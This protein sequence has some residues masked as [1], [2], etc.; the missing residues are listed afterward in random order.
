LVFLCLPQISN[1]TSENLK[2]APSDALLIGQTMSVL[3]QFVSDLFLVDKEIEVVA[4]QRARAEAKISLHLSLWQHDLEMKEQS[5]GS[6]AKTFEW[7]GPLVGVTKYTAIAPRTPHFCKHLSQGNGNVLNGSLYIEIWKPQPNIMTL[8]LQKVYPIISGGGVPNK[9][10]PN[11]LLISTIHDEKWTIDLEFGADK[12][13]D[14]VS[15][16]HDSETH[17][18]LTSYLED[19]AT[20]RIADRVRHMAQGNIQNGAS[21]GLKRTHDK[22]V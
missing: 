3:D 10:S 7:I 5:H 13:L 16:T 9:A 1:V 2:D 4:R 14:K 19:T 15:F 11:K 12:V 18:N 21:V 22:I 20:S 8:E 6:E 17:P